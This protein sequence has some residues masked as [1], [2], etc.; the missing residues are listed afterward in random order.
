MNININEILF[1][2]GIG[3]KETVYMSVSPSVGLEVIKVDTSSKMITAYAN[4]KLEYN[5][6]LREIADYEEFKA[7]VKDSFE[8][9]HIS[10]H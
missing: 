7:A 10:L 3:S 9:L 5:E 4:R 8:E 6:S 2:L 1:Q